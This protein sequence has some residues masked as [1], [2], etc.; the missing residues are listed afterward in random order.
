MFSFR[1]T[2]PVSNR[3]VDVRTKAGNAKPDHRESMLCDRAA[4]CVANARL[5]LG[6]NDLLAMGDA[7]TQALRIIDEGLKSALD[8]HSGRVARELSMLCDYMSRS[9]TTAKLQKND[10]LYAEVETLLGELRGA[11]C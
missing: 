7:T 10:A 2:L 3:T 9:L 8:I 11:W 4:F 6:R 1:R 5:A